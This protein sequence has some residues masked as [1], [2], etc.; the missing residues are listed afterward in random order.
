MIAKPAQLDHRNT[1]AQGQGRRASFA[2]KNEKGIALFIA[3]MLLALMSV[4]SLAMVL[5][6][7]PDM[8][9]NG[10]YGNFRGSFY[11]ADSGLNIARQTLVN[12]ISS[13]TYVNQTV[14]PSGWGPGAANVNCRGLPLDNSTGPNGAAGKVITAVLSSG[15]GGYGSYT[16]L[17]SGQA[18]NSWPGSF[19]LVNSATC[20]STFVPETSTPTP[21]WPPATTVTNLAYKFDYQLCSLGRAQGGQQVYTSEHGTVTVS[22][23]TSGTTR[24][25]AF[26]AWGG[27]VSNYPTN[28]APLI[29]GV[30]EGP[31]FTNGAW[32]FEPGQ[33]IFTGPV[34]QVSPNM[35]FS[36]NG[37]CD[38][39]AA[40][41]N[42]NGVTISPQFSVPPNLNQSPILLPT[43]DFSQKWAVLD[44]VG[45]GEAGNPL[46]NSGLAMNNPSPAQMS[47]G[48]KDINGNA[49]PS[50]SAPN[51][52]VFLAYS[53]SG[54]C[55]ATA[56]MSGGGIYVEGSASV[57][58]STGTNANTGNLNQ[59]YKITQG[60]TVTTVTVPV[61]NPANNAVPTGAGAYTT[62]AS[63]GTTTIVSGFPMNNVN[64]TSPQPGTLLY[65][66]GTISSLQGPGQSSTITTGSQAGAI[67]NPAIQSHSQLTV[68]ANQDVNITGDLRYTFDPNT[69]D[70]TDTYNKNNPTSGLLQDTGQAF[71]VFTANGN[72]VLGSNPSYST[73]DLYVDGALA[74]IGQ[75]CGAC[76]FTTFNHI[77]NFV[78]YGSQAQTNIFGADMNNQIQYYDT[79]FAAGFGPPWFP[80]AMVTQNDIN[81][82][83]PSVYTT[84]NRLSWSTSPQ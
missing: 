66:N 78:N 3:L 65:V 20:P 11:A 47:A 79:R 7:S 54:S 64:N 8:L 55:P 76:G 51:S 60:S 14:C 30:F 41:D 71:G 83:A 25:Y 5:T 45:C 36:N 46:C 77:N 27:F 10:Y 52:G 32:Q 69:Q 43:N 74:P 53:C 17:N 67:I 23:S 63:G 35:D 44:G 2:A 72:I 21:P 31:Y 61:W 33:Y 84:V 50:G 57:V 58:L 13:A 56:T 15:S 1:S 59:I 81:P 29:P 62:I 24:A 37:W 28:Y 80:T 12:Q 19:E 39:A 48:L 68:V 49:Y 70:T 34:G 40:S 9:I 4:M 82:G 38:V 42:C 6:V 26:S 75:N 22:L 73:Q 16:S 18:G